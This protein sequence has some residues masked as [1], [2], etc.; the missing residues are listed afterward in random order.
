MSTPRYA[1]EQ[2]ALWNGAAGRA[3]VDAQELLDGIYRPIE[4][5]LADVV[6]T[7]S[8]STVLDVGCGTG[9][10]TLAAARRLAPQGRALG[11]DL[12]EVMIAVARARAE[13]EGLPAVFASADAQV[14]PF[15]RSSVDAIISRFGVMFF[16]DPVRAFTNVRAAARDGAEAR[17]AVWRSAAEN[18][19]MTTAERA[20]APLL[21]K[22]PP[23]RP[24]A[25]GQF[26]L[27]DRDRVYSI[28]EESGWTAI[29]IRPFDLECTFPEPELVRYLTRL[30]PVGMALQQADDQTRAK[31]VDVARAAFEPYVHGAQVGFTAA[32]WIVAARAGVR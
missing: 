20:A 11:V 27:A 14:F 19:F 3:W 4:Q 8:P 9:A 13:R 23:R 30:G 32:C 29:D 5:L 22:L 18:L 6:P 16:D 2:V 25:P 28:L 7:G 31:V 21:P 15:E 12:S 17:L 10:T 24:D 26:A 1:D